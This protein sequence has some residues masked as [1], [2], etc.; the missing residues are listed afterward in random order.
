MATGFV[1]A[2]AALLALVFA[3]M[4]CTVNYSITN[5][6]TDTHGTASDVV[7]ETSSEKATTETQATANITAKPF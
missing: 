4:G 2:G 6:L 1:C 3:L 5:T 7:D